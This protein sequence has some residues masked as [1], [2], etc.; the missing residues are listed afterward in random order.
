MQGTKQNTHPSVPLNLI[1]RKCV[2]KKAIIDGGQ[3]QGAYIVS[4]TH[5]RSQMSPAVVKDILAIGVTLQV[6]GY[7]CMQLLRL[8]MPYQHVLRK[9][10]L[11]LDLQQPSLCQYNWQAACRRSPAYFIEHHHWSS[12]ALP[13]ELS[14]MESNLSSW[15]S[16]FCSHASDIA[17]AGSRK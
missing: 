3:A 14:S 6:Q 5:T 12:T 7:A 15:T 9:P 16:M 4:L 1:A 10:T 17:K 8:C 13:A 11:L 2:R